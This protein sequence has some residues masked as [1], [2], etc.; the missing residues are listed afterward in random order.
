MALAEKVNAKEM[1]KI[2]QCLEIVMDGKDGGV[3]N[4]SS[5]VEDIEDNILVLAMPMDKGYPIIPEAGT[6]VTGRIV[7]ERAAY[8]L[9]TIYLGKRANPIPV[10]LVKMPETMKRYQQREFVRIDVLLNGSVQCEDDDENLLPVEPVSIRNLSGGGAQLAFNRKVSIGKRLYLSCT[11][12]GIGLLRVYSEV[13][14]TD[15]MINQYH[16]FAV[17]FLNM[18]EKVRVQLIR[19]IFDCQRKLLRH[20]K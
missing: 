7:D 5:R 17:K 10:W 1:I 4:Y 15:E 16:V 14:R 9:D 6:M 11:I 12:P 13:V 19:Y 3:V 18:S 8:K 20:K 2:G